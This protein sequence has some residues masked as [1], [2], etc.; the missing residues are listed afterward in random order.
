MIDYNKWEYINEFILNNIKSNKNIRFFIND[1]PHLNNKNKL[2]NGVDN[3]I[4]DKNDEIINIF[5]QI[6]STYIIK[7]SI[8]RLIKQTEINEFFD[9]ILTFDENLLKLPNSYKLLPLL[10]YSWVR[11]PSELGVNPYIK[12]HYGHTLSCE[13]NKKNFNISMLCGDKTFAPGHKIRH[14][15]WN[16]QNYITIPKKFYKPAYTENLKIFDDNITISSK[17]DKTEMFDSMFHICVEN[18][19]CKDYF[20]EKILDCIVSKTIP[21][22]YGCPNIGDYF[23]IKGMIIVD[24]LDDCIEKVNKLT[25]EDYFKILP[26]VEKNFRIYKLLPN[27]ETQINNFLNII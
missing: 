12:H 16:K 22:Y 23:D 21:V 17:R 6:E 18:N 10:N 3:K 27:F 7:N 8:D 11:Y 4:L 26:Y 2:I 5:I 14:D 9:Y 25:E 24:N 1:S 20:T 19:N 13:Y 15:I